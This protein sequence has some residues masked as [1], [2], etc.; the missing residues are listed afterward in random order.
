MSMLPVTSSKRTD[1]GLIQEGPRG[2]QAAAARRSIAGFRAGDWVQVR[3]KEEILGTLDANGRLDEL[4]FMPEML[5]FCGKVMRI[6]KRAHKTCDPALGIGGRKMSGTVHLENVR[7]NG[8]AHDGCEAG[9]LIFWKEA[10]LKPLDGAAQAASACASPA[11]ARKSCAQC[12]EAVLHT[13]LKTPPAPGE[14]E[15]TYVCQNTQIKFATQPLPWWD[16]RQYVEDYTSGN[17]PLSQLAVG[18][19]YSSWRTVAEAGIGVGTAMRWIYDRFQSAIGGSPYPVRPFGVP[20][21]SPVPK[22]QLDLQPGERVRVKPY[23]E[24]LTTLD[25]NYR[26]RGLYFD[27]EMVPFTERE[28]EVE[29]RQKQIIDERTGKMVRFKTDA[30][31]LKDVVC[32]ARYAICRRFCPRAIYPYWREIWLERASE[33]CDQAAKPERS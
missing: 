29:R 14:T 18:L 30:I 2:A 28:Y 9:C 12:T 13:S 21:G 31:V 4:P 25:C 10:W 26:N 19:L 15:P 33:P 3:S 6:G 5:A 32:E 23:E 20:E 7:C 8:A 1:L 27:A 24:I 11:G 22:A 17:V 16:I